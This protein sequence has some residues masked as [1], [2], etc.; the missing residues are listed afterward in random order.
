MFS[1]SFTSQEIITCCPYNNLIT[2]DLPSCALTP[3][4]HFE[5]LHQHSFVWCCPTD[6]GGAASD[7][8]AAR[9]AG[10]RIPP[11]PS[12]LTEEEV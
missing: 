10:D 1:S 8:G 12:V 7:G 11:E 4:T 3:G 2:S 9:P 6:D 5:Y